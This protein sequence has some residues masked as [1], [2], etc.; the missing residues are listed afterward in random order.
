MCDD[1]EETALLTFLLQRVGLTVSVAPG[2]EKGLRVLPGRAADLVV[3]SL[4]QSSPSAQVRRV[5]R[6]TEAC[7]VVVANNSDEDDLCRAFDAGA[8]LI[9]V[10]PYSVRLVISQIR[11]LMRRSR[12][13]V[14]SV[15]PVFTIGP[16]SL[17]PSTRVIR[18]KG[19]APRR[20]THLEFRLLYT[21][22]LHRGQTV[23]TETIVERV[24]GYG[25]E[26]DI[27]LVRGLVGRLRVKVEQDP[28]QPQY[29]L[30]VPYLGYRLEI[31]ET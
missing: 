19:R 26:G 21:L 5:R 27:R 20:L 31:S 18:I 4:R 22:M 6:D 25:G 16:L 9:V 17:D 7:L 8:D 12:G 29:V 3:L 30:T 28:K 11:A 10:R 14:L 23:P 13:T 24:W 1:A 2:L 15:L